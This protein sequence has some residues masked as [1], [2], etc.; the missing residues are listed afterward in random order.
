MPQIYTAPV[1]YTITQTG[2]AG[3]VVGSLTNILDRD[4]YTFYQTNAAGQT[5][6]NPTRNELRF[7]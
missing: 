4:K 7:T 6:N 5:F 1:N 2:D 3:T